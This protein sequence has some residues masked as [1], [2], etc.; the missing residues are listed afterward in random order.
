[1]KRKTFITGM[2]GS[3]KTT[4]A[5]KFTKEH[6]IPFINFD[7]AFDYNKSKDYK[8]VK[9]FYDKLPKK[10]VI[11]AVPFNLGWNVFIEYLNEHLDVDLIYT[12]CS[13]PITWCFRII[14]KWAF[15]TPPTKEYIKE[16]LY[17]SFEQYAG[18]YYK[19]FSN[20]EGLVPYQIFDTY[21]NEY[22]SK[23]ELYKRINWSLAIYK[24]KK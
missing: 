7:T 23:E 13:N 21:T 3:G 15:Q 19:S 11:D 16:L 9:K 12:V 10:F 6:N 5:L 22:I 1:M 14:D 2:S 24:E 17:S 18:L 8:Y 20:I 4:Y